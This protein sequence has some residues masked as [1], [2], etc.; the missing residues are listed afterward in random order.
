MGSGPLG[1]TPCKVR[2]MLKENMRFHDYYE[3]KK[4]IGKGGM[5]EVWLVEDLRNHSLWAMKEQDNRSNARNEGRLLSYFN[6]PALP[7]LHEMFVE[8]DRLFIV[9]GYMKGQSIDHLI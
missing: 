2:I 1:F 4:S 7:A 6:H 9:M 8:D 5:G 3:I